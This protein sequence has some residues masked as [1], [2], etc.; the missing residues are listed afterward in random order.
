MR[1]FGALSVMASFL[2]QSVIS[3]DPDVT[4][5]LHEVLSRPNA[6][7]NEIK[8]VLRLALEDVF[9]FEGLELNSGD[10]SPEVTTTS[11]PTRGKLGVTTVSPSDFERIAAVEIANAS[12]LATDE[13]LAALTKM[14]GVDDEPSETKAISLSSTTTDEI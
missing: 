4:E 11:S 12:D 3:V 10:R 13:V 14:F 6:P 9:P 5:M 7:M 8:D 2:S 1:P